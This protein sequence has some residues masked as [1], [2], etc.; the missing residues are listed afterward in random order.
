[1]P[2]CGRTWTGWKGVPDRQAITLLLLPII[3]LGVALAYRVLA[4]AWPHFGNTRPALLVATPVF[5]LTVLLLWIVAA[6]L[7]VRMRGVRQAT[8]WPVS[9]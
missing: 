1:M 2:V 9:A 8:E 5:R 3:K 7:L 6:F 4:G